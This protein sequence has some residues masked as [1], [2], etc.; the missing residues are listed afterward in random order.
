M[1]SKDNPKFRTSNHVTAITF[2][3]IGIITAGTLFVS[4]PVLN[5]NQN[6]T[7]MA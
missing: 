3:L 7:A 6:H 1:V 2:F 4:T 5:Q